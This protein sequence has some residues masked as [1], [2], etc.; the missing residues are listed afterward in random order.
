MAFPNSQSNPASAIPVWIASAPAGSGS[1]QH[2]VNLTTN[3][4]LPITTGPTLLESIIVGVAGVTSTI[5]VDDGSSVKLTLSTTAV[6]VYPVN[7]PIATA[8]NVT[9][10]GGT[11]AN[12]TL[13]YSE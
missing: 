1:T 13:I 5:V 10:A 7:I 6:N 8:L 11:A 2:V 9:T 3:E 4:T 12:I